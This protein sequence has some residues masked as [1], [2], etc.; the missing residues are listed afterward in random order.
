MYGIPGK[1]FAEF[2]KVQYPSG[3]WK[4]WWAESRPFETVLSERLEPYIAGGYETVVIGDN[5]IGFCMVQK[6]V[7][8]VFVF[9]QQL[10]NEHACCQGGGLLVAILAKELGVACNLYPTDFDPEKAATGD[11]LS[12]AGHNITPPG[13]HSYIPG[14]DRVALSYFSERW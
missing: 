10:T 6:K 5:M 12:F 13:S 11:S 8:T 4:L 3:Q 7:N 14:A 2:L 1:E 9:Y